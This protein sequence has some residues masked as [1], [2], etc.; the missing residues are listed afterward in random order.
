MQLCSSICGIFCPVISF[1]R[2]APMELFDPGTDTSPKLGKRVLWGFGPQDQE[3]RIHLTPA[4]EPINNN[5]LNLFHGECCS[6]Q[7]MQYNPGEASIL[8]PVVQGLVVVLPFWGLLFSCT[9]QDPPTKFLL[10]TEE[11]LIWA[12]GTCNHKH[13]K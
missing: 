9:T 10:C 2:T 11:T 1:L 13:S 5:T 3:N 7:G 4:T 12:S 6:A 8:K